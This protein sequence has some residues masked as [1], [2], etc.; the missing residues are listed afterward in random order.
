MIPAT[1][2]Y[3]PEL[4]GERPST[5]DTANSQTTKGSGDSGTAEPQSMIIKTTVKLNSTNSVASVDS[6]GDNALS[7]NRR[8]KI[9]ESTMNYGDGGVTFINNGEQEDDDDITID[10]ALQNKQVKKI[11]FRS[12]SVKKAKEIVISGQFKN[13]PL[14]GFIKVHKQR[15]IDADPDIVKAM[16][17]SV[18][19][20]A[21]VSSS[22]TAS[23]RG[24]SLRQGLTDRPMKE[25][26]RASSPVSGHRESMRIKGFREPPR[27][28][29]KKLE[30]LEQKLVLKR[31][32][33]GYSPQKKAQILQTTLTERYSGHE[34]LLTSENLKADI[35]NTQVVDGTKTLRLMALAEKLDR[36]RK[37]EL[38]DSHAIDLDDLMEN[39]LTDLSLSVEEGD[40]HGFDIMN[41]VEGGF[42]SLFSD[43]NP[44]ADTANTKD[45]NNKE[46]VKQSGR[47]RRKDKDAASITSNQSVDTSVHMDDGPATLTKDP[48]LAS[49]RHGVERMQAMEGK[50]GLAGE[51]ELEG[52]IVPSK[53]GATCGLV[54]L[55]GSGSRLNVKI[56]GNK[57][58]GQAHRR[59][60][61][62][63]KEAEKAKKSKKKAG[64]H[65]VH[66]KLQSTQNLDNFKLKNPS[67]LSAQAPDTRDG[68][69]PPAEAPFYEPKTYR[70]P[71]TMED[72]LRNIPAEPE[73]E[74]DM[75]SYASLD[76]YASD[77]E[78]SLPPST[79]GQDMQ[80][81]RKKFFHKKVKFDDAVD[82]DSENDEVGL[83]KEPDNF[84]FD[85]A[86]E[87]D[88]DD[89]DDDEEDE[90]EEEEEEGNGTDVGSAPASAA[91]SDIPGSAGPVTD[92]IP[93]SAASATSN[94]SQSQAPK[95]TPMAS[96]MASALSN[97]NKSSDGGL[98]DPFLAVDLNQGTPFPGA[99]PSRP[100]TADVP[101]VPVDQGAHA[102]GSQP[103]ATVAEQTEAPTISSLTAV[104]D[105]NTTTTTTTA[106]VAS[107]GNLNLNLN[108]NP[109]VG[110]SAYSGSGSGSL[111]G[112]TT[113]SGEN[114]RERDDDYND[115]SVSR[116]MD[117]SISVVRESMVLDSGPAPSMPGSINP[118]DI[119]LPLLTSQVGHEGSLAGSSIESHLSHPVHP[120]G[121][122]GGS[123][124]SGSIMSQDALATMLGQA[125]ASEEL[126]AQEREQNMANDEEM[127]AEHFRNA[128]ELEERRKERYV[129][130]RGLIVYVHV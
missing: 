39:S 8:K 22:Y 50:T 28:Y 111:I 100:A 92:S 99:D 90:D 70:R 129:I 78:N 2:I 30:P 18:N 51:Q 65:V 93:G 47:Q 119:S 102:Y 95:S 24:L 57:K 45:S 13:K 107:S 41:V 84:E 40:V 80:G 96:A 87:E 19:G 63:L 54:L 123:V 89:D 115:R 74:F 9:I 118:H 94:K 33:Y 67:S 38:M 58:T 127:A 128:A 23:L 12:P 104:G 85:L 26:T 120:G 36:Q 48:S 91:A 6:S 1:E 82:T 103:I 79:K 3:K 11:G 122:G 4:R 35:L 98:G 14:P 55:Q 86:F 59:M 20:P 27:D 114:M 68:A 43:N 126:D 37:Q 108:N 66:V 105:P 88:D 61:K 116:G 113:S 53:S 64:K 49:L 44:K 101:D 71:M 56:G 62:K 121:T 7:R 106:A 75:Q 109:G 97:N 110:V 17:K 83:D 125:L 130:V 34:D 60:M 31:Y 117:A 76:H 15:N 29:L 81:W 32:G 52:Y 69:L 25:R 42:D 73:S 112:K 124:D 10:S 46:K 21:M 16:N 72:K 5:A 77:L